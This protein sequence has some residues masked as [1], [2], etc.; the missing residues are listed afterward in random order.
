M[1]QRTNSETVKKHVSIYLAH[2]DIGEQDII[3]CEVCGK[4]GRVDSGGFDIHHVVFRSRG[5]KDEIK[6]LMCLC[7]TPQ[8]KGCH[9]K[10]HS[11]EYKEGELKLIHGYFM[12]GVRKRFK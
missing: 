3:T 6:N 1:A 4:Q 11:E 9:D 10:A 7:R 5:G 2:F 8:G 12:A